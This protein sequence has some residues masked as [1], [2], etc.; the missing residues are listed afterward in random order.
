MDG[1]AQQFLEHPRR[2]WF[3][4]GAVAA[5]GLAVT[6]PAWDSWAA[7]S[8][9]R[10]TLTAART[11]AEA[12]AGRLPDL[13]ARFMA[14]KAEPAGADGP[15]GLDD[16]AMEELRE[17]VVR[18][19]AA[20]GCRMRRVGLEDPVTTPWRNGPP[21]L[22]GLVDRSSDPPAGAT[23]EPPVKFEL[24]T[25][26]LEAEAVGSP[27]RIAS[28]LNWATAAHPHAV[29]LDYHLTF[30]D[31]PDVAA[32][33]VHLTFSLLLTAVRPLKQSPKS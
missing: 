1:L 25:R 33:E 24:I 14:L 15:R 16:A 17:S 18:R 28:L 31:A 19:I 23:N 11:A 32:R 2:H 8:E 29:P 6:L 3:V 9:A 12:E 21:P 26:R 5:V 10:A 30:E 27:E 13:K 7:A 20:A 4:W 22:P